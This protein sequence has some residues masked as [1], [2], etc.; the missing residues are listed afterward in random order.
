M[1]DYSNS[2]YVQFMGESGLTVMGMPGQDLYDL[3]GQEDGN[4]KFAEYV[5]IEL[6]HKPISMLLMVKLDTYGESTDGPRYK[7]MCSKIYEHSYAE[8]NQ[9][10]LDKLELY[11][12]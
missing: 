7:Y 10:L 9:N 3:M 8:D 11:S 6:L 1:E 4:A 5:T 12:K 2:I